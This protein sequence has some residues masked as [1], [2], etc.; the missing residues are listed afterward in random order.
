MAGRDE[1]WKNWEDVRV[2]LRTPEW[3]I[4]SSSSWLHFYA[5]LFV[6]VLNSVWTQP[7]TNQNVPFQ[8]QSSSNWKISTAFQCIWALMF[9]WVPAPTVMHSTCILGI[10]PG[11]EV[12]Y[13]FRF[14]LSTIRFFKIQLGSNKKLR[15]LSE[16]YIL[17][18]LSDASPLG[19]QPERCEHK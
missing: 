16:C 17:S 5:F 9:K 19:M 2:E 7:R 12:A 10:L 15:N 11:F 8:L 6:C 14:P 3:K 13:L 18:T 1:T 4:H